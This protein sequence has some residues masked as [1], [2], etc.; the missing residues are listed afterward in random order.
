MVVEARNIYLVHGDDT[1]EACPR[2][3]ALKSD[4][5]VPQLLVGVTITGYYIS[6]V[7]HTMDVD[8]DLFVTDTMY[9][10]R[11]PYTEKEMV[12]EH[13]RAATLREFIVTFNENIRDLYIVSQNLYGINLA[14]WGNRIDR[15]WTER[16]TRQYPIVGLAFY[17]R[18]GNNVYE[19]RYYPTV[20]AKNGMRVVLEDYTMFKQPIPR[21]MDV[22]TLSC[23]PTLAVEQDPPRLTVLSEEQL[24]LDDM[25]GAGIT[26]PLWY[27]RQYIGA[28][29]RHDFLASIPQLDQ[30]R[31]ERIT[32]DIL[33]S[34]R[35]LAL[36]E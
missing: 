11:D 28:V 1:V 2:I 31:K 27:T 3:I 20:P 26:V 35:Q 7:D 33:L 17:E 16:V 15:I 10:M 6:R 30:E 32:R 29:S 12:E 19:W 34:P 21:E 5:D 36:Y 24:G 23:R 9:D 18:D 14:E 4:V 22:I 13:T 8:G 25:L